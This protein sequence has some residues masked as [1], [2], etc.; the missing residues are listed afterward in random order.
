MKL[1]V[2]KLREFRHAIEVLLK[3]PEDFKAVA[4]AVEERDAKT[5]QAVLS[6]LKLIP[7]CHW[8]CRWFCTKVSIFICRR[9][10]PED[11][12]VKDTIEEM[13]EFA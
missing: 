3:N 11:V 2:D 12:A 1:E 6:R 13:M 4:Q 9:F 8:V 10:C 7:I 5:Y